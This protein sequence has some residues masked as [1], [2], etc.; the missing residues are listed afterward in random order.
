MTVMEKTIG[1]FEV[2]RN[3][4]KVLQGV[5]RGDKVVVEKNGAPVAVVV[6]IELYERWKQRRAAFFKQIQA[7]AEEANLS[8][9]EAEQLAAEAIA[10]TRA[11]GRA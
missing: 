7:M 6:P 11:E 8:E 10:A 1:A 2:R 3:F 9:P 4:G 5:T